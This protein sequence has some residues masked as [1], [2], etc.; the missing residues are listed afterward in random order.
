MGFTRSG[1]PVVPVEG[2]HSLDVME[3][4]DSSTSSEVMWKAWPSAA[5]MPSRPQKPFAKSS[6]CVTVHSDVPW[7]QEVVSEGFT[8]DPKGRIVRP[9]TRPGLGIEIDEAV[10]KKHPFQQE[11][12]LRLFGRHGSVI[13]W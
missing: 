2:C 1:V 8:V 6:A 9:N 13:D 11:T 5:P 12:V 3:T 10:V 7:R 4:A